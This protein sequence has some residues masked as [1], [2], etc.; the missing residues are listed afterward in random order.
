VPSALES[1]RPG[2][3]FVTK[4]WQYPVYVAGCLSDEFDGCVVASGFQNI[5]V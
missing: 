4:V 1:R 2:Q 5:S 3:T